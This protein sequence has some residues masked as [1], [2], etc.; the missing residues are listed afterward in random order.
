MDKDNLT[1]PQQYHLDFLK[2]RYEHH[3]KDQEYP[4]TFALEDWLE[5]ENG[6]DLDD[7]EFTIIIR[8]F[9]A[10]AMIQQRKLN[11]E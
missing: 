3:K 2:S 6:A 11:L 9:T 1:E 10:W 7:S 5:G 4:F 8:K